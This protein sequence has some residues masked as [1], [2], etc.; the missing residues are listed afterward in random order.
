VGE[1]SCRAYRAVEKLAIFP[2]ED[3]ATAVLPG[4]RAAVNVSTLVSNRKWSGTVAAQ[5]RTKRAKVPVKATTTRRPAACRKAQILAR[6]ARP[7]GTLAEIAE[8]TGWQRHS[9]RGFMA[10]GTVA[11]HQ[12]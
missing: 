6:V 4:I 3:Q 11:K 9:V 5:G 10:T 12:G 1:I 2:G 8:A 7:R